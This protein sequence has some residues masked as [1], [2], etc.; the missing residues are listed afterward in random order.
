[1]ARQ[2][3]LIVLLA[4]LRGSSNAIITELARQ[5]ESA[6][7]SLAN[8]HLAPLRYLDVLFGT[9]HGIVPFSRGIQLS[10]TATIGSQTG[11]YHP[12]SKISAGV[13][14]GSDLITIIKNPRSPYSYGIPG[15]DYPTYL[16]PFYRKGVR[17]GAGG[18]LI[19]PNGLPL[20]PNGLPI[21]TDGLPIS[22]FGPNGLP[23]GPLGPNGYPY[24]P[25]GPTPIPHIVPVPVIAGNNI[26][27]PRGDLTVDRTIG[28]NTPFGGGSINLDTSVG[29]NRIH[30]PGVQATAGGGAGV[31]SGGGWFGNGGVL[32]TGLFGAKGLLGTGVLSSKSLSLG[33]LNPFGLPLPS[34][35]INPFGNIFGSL[36]NLFGFGGGVQANVGS[37]I[38]K[39]PRSHPLLPGVEGSITVDVG[40]SLAPPTGLLGMI[41]PLLNIFG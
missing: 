23:Y 15:Y 34:F 27:S 9:N 33:F 26:R 19:G 37:Q 18:V 16:K 30:G 31:G 6:V 20:A 36:G 4:L 8:L 5:G 3:I 32:G 40:G 24:L 1:M 2:L 28:I 12:Y 39:A 22:P 17:V 38:V 21:G 35:I 41:H 10:K 11:D 13:G 29:L 7:Q 25:F 14:Q